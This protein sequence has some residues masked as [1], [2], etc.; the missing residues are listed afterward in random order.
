MRKLGLAGG[1]EPL[2]RVLAIGAHSDDLEIG[3][4]GDDPALTRAQGGPQ[5]PLG[6]ARCGRGR[7]GDEARASA[8]SFLAAAG[9]VEVEILSF[10]DGFLPHAS[11]EVKD[12][13]ES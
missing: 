3:C 12:A 9:D 4:G 7:P 1:D 8:E 13:F 10:R 5:R 6:R 11:S 2:R